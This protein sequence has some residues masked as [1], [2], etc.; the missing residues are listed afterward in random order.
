MS[1]GISRTAHGQTL[2]LSQ[3]LTH[4]SEIPPFNMPLFS[5]KKMG[6]EKIVPAAGPRQR[7]NSLF[8]KLQRRQKIVE[9]RD[10][11]RIE[12]IQEVSLHAGSLGS[13]VYWLLLAHCQLNMELRF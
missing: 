9:Q 7:S 4:P 12:P 2:K 13:Y 10:G 11:D 5:K 8:Q 1:F 6:Q 3:I